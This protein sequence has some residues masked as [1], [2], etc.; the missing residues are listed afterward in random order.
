[1]EYKLINNKDGLFVDVNRNGKKML[2]VIKGWESFTGWYWFATEESEK[3]PAADSI[4]GKD[5]IVYFGLVQGQEEELGYFNT[6]ELRDLIRRGMVWELKGGNL[7]C[8][9]RR[10]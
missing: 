2:K 10:H 3:I 4:T 7:T 1:M 8:A 6:M 5:E 9:G